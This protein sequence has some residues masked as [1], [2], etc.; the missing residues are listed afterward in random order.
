MVKQVII[1]T[2]QQQQQEQQNKNNENIIYTCQF[3]DNNFYGYRKDNR[4]FCSRK[5]LYK[6]RT[7]YYTCIGCQIKFKPKCR[8][9]PKFCSKK[10]Y[11]ANRGLC[12]PITP[13]YDTHY[14]CDFC[15]T[16]IPHKQA[17]VNSKSQPVCPK[18]GCNKNR[19]K[20]K[21]L[22]PKFNHKRQIPKRID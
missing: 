21:S 4:K 15:L 5:C 11:N 10:C 2:Q 22:Y 1:L 7:H 17:K 14:Y 18:I 8:I 19:L 9:N 3:C 13:K 12:K 6:S 20:T 16:W